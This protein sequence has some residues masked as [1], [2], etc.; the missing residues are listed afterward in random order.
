MYATFCLLSCTA[1]SLA[2]LPSGVTVA[3]TRSTDAQVAAT[4]CTAS[5]CRQFVAIKYEVNRHQHKHPE[6][7]NNFQQ[8][9]SHHQ[10]LPRGAGGFGMAKF[11]MAKFGQILPWYLRTEAIRLGVMVVPFAVYACY[12][13]FCMV[14]PPTPVPANIQTP[15]G[16]TSKRPD[17]TN[18]QIRAL[19]GRVC[20]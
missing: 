4:V 15:L 5:K 7:T 12:S 8:P 11:G 18:H 13:K 6:T 1:M 9:F 3:Y 17:T 10:E 16:N 19:P 14:T 2:W 20:S